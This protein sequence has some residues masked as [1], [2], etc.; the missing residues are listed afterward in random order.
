MEVKRAGAGDALSF[1]VTVTDAP[2]AS[3][4]RVTLDASQF[5]R[6]RRGDETPEQFVGR[7]FDFLL[8]REPQESIMS[9]FDVSVISRYFPEFEREISG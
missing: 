7:C 1:H 4:H 9:S 8:A 3:T 6:L 2:S 5:E